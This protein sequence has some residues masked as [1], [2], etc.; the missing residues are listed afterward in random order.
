[1]KSRILVR[2]LVLKSLFYECLRELR[3]LITPR[4]VE[5]HAEAKNEAAFSGSPYSLIQYF[6]ERFSAQIMTLT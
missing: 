2:P 5:R 1:M 4:H 6:T 3:S